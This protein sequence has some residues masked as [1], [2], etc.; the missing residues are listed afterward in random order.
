VSYR[1]EQIL[2]DDDFLKCLPLALDANQRLILEGLAHIADSLW[3]SYGTLNAIATRW[4]QSDDSGLPS[5]D[6]AMM[7]NCAWSIVDDIHAARQL[8]HR[9]LN[10]PPSPGGFRDSTEAFHGLRNKMDHLAGNV[11]NLA[12]AKG[13]RRPIFGTLS[14]LYL[15]PEHLDVSGVPVRGRSYMTTAGSASHRDMFSIITP[16][17]DTVALPIDDYTLGAF[18]TE[19]RLGSAIGQFRRAVRALS[20]EVCSSCRREVE[21]R[22]G[23]EADVEKALANANPYGVGMIFD[24]EFKYPDLGH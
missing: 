14:F 2:A 1:G 5:F 23:T 24:F 3:A 6:R 11:G 19:V 21:K 22:A 8:F 13:L 10:K 7:F 15:G 20:E 9:L 4:A 12:K 18:D 16:H 17:G